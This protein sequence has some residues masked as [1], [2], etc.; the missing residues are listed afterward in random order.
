L[1]T[2]FTTQSGERAP[3]APLTLLVQAFDRRLGEALLDRLRPD[4]PGINA[5]HLA[6]FAALDCGVTHAAAAAARMG[7]SRQAVARTARELDRLGYL[8]LEA[9]PAARNRQVLAM[10]DAGLR[11]ATAGQAALADLEVELAGRIGPG[12]AEALR[13]ALERE[14]ATQGG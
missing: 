9:D 6:L 2:T 13:R 10:T 12:A 14:W 8:R 3:P 11:L 1:S 4:F 7:I 5:A